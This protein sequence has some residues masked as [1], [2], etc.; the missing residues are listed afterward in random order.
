[1]EQGDDHMAADAVAGH[2]FML[3]KPVRD[4]CLA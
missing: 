1:M 2:L 3:M 4:R